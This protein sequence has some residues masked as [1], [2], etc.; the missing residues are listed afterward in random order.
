MPNWCMTNLIIAGNETELEGL[1]KL[2][3]KWTSKEYSPSDFKSSW[4]GNIVLGAGFK[5][6]DDETE[7]FRCR[8]AVDWIGNVEENEQRLAYLEIEYESAW[9]PMIAM[10]YAVAEKYAPHCKVYFYAEEPGFELYQSNDTRH[11]FFEEDYV[12][13]FYTDDTDNKFLR[14]GFENGITRYDKEDVEK[15][16]QKVYPGKLLPEMLL[17]AE[18]E[19]EKLENNYLRIHTIDFIE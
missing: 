10:W 15:M 19:M 1:E 2:L 8:G 13:D 6:S 17:L 14:A 11:I 3:K 18:K 16:L 7:E 5:I 12:V 4:L 9:E